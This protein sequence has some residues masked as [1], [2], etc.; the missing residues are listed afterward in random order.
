MPRS[1]PTATRRFGSSIAGDS[2]PSPASTSAAAGEVGGVAHPD[3]DPVAPGLALQLARRA[4]GD[5]LAV[6]DDHDVVGELVGLLEVL[7]R[8]QHVGAGGDERPDRVPQLDAAA[9]VETGRRLVEQ[10]QAGCA[11]EAGA[12]VEAAAHAARVAADETVGRV[13]EAELL[14]DVVGGDP[15]GRTTVPEQAGDHDEVLAAG[16]RASTAA[17]WPARPIA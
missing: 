2:S 16:Q 1:T 6:V 12:E 15:G 3:L 5:R 10:Q 4:R 14:E 13:V 7:R 11:D 17:D 9:R 8:Q